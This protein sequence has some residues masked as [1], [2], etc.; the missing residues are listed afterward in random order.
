MTQ[1]EIFYGTEACVSAALSTRYDFRKAHE[2]EQRRKAELAAIR[3]AMSA[4]RK[5]DK[6][7][8]QIRHFNQGAEFT[9]WA[10]LVD[11]VD[12]EKRETMLAR[13]AANGKGAAGGHAAA[14]SQ[15]DAASRMDIAAKRKDLRKI[16]DRLS[17][18]WPRINA[19]RTALSNG[20]KQAPRLTGYAASV[21]M[22]AVEMYERMK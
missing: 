13:F 18:L 15:S 3:T 16:S 6:S 12:G 2:E 8:T 19:G 22:L 10:E 5:A 11:G 20:F 21:A 7:M 14:E 17:A 9:Y 4:W 1:T